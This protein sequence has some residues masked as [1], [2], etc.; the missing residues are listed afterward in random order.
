MKESD[1]IEYRQRKFTQQ[2][3]QRMKRM[4][5]AVAQFKYMDPK[6][7]DGQRKILQCAECLKKRPLIGGMDPKRIPQPFVCWMNNWDETRASCSAPQG[8][9]PSREVIE[10]TTT[11]TTTTT[12]T[13]GTATGTNGTTSGTTSGTGTKKCT[14]GGASHGSSHGSNKKASVGGEKKATKSNNTNKRNSSSSSM[15]SHPSHIP[16][17]AKLSNSSSKR[18]KRR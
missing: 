18:P 3:L 7:D 8:F 4:E 16:T 17:T 10:Y 9:I 1:L 15:N 11:T 12:T 5:K 6:E 14:S 13:I 2:F